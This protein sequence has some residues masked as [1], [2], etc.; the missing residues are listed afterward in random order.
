M[1]TNNQSIRHWHASDQPRE[2]LLHL[3]AQSLSQAEL[4]AILIRSG[5]QK[6]SAVELSRQLLSQYN[7]NLNEL[8]KCGPDQL[9]KFKGIGE[10]KALSI[11]TALELGRR[12]QGTS[13]HEYPRIQS[14]EAAY[15][16]LRPYVEDRHEEIFCVLY[17]NNAN[18][19]IQVKVIGS[20]GMTSTLVDVRVIFRWALSLR[21]TG[22]ILCHNHP[23]GHVTPSQA[24]K[25]I[26]QKISACG[27]LF[28]IR[29][30][31]HLI[32]GEKGYFSFADEG[33]I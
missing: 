31:D 26:T 21:A 30:L 13:P 14:S 2:K 19:V 11:I 25:N 18:K 1:E 6:A 32:V 12:R 15:Q 16:Y 5:S 33:L 4:I 27:K 22:M 17:M 29:A 8:A 10:A 24:D 7:N 23:S 3:G 20:G 9:Q 28:D